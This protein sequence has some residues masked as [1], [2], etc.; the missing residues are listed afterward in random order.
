MAQLAFDAQVFFEQG[1]RVLVFALVEGQPTEAAQRE[2]HAQVVLGLPEEVARI[3]ER[4]A[5]RGD[6]AL[7]KSQ[8]AQRQQRPSAH[9]R[10]WRVAGP[11][12]QPAQ[13]RPTFAEVA[14]QP[15]EA[16]DRARQAQPAPVRI[17]QS[18]L[19][20]EHR[21]QVTVLGFESI[22]PHDLGRPRQ[23]GRGLLRRAPGSTR[24]AVRGRPP[25]RRALRVGHARTGSRVRA[26]D[27]GARRPRAAR[28]RPATYRPGARAH[29][30]RPRSRARQSAH[31]FGGFERPRPGK[32]ASRRN[33]RCSC[34]E[35]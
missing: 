28:P 24:H 9:A 5:R 3:L 14:A 32:I 26:A 8:L 27:S 2:R 31:D 10:R 23:L 25:V 19:P 33:R 12:E 17:A 21:A 16:P 34:S 30:A 6:V 11:I 15:P 13:L 20:F 18:M 29:P 35:S 1:A 4:R 7:P 22:Q